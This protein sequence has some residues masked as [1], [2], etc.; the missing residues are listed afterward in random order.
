MS[1]SHK[2]KASG[3]NHKETAKA[4]DLESKEVLEEVVAQLV[5]DETMKP[6]I[7]ID[8]DE[9]PAQDAT[10]AQADTSAEIEDMRNKYLRLLAEYDNFRKRSKAERETTYRDARS[11]AVTRFLPI[12]DNLE[13]ALKTEC[14]DEAFYKGIEMTM[15]HLTEIMQSLDVVEI[16]AV[17][18]PFDPNRHNAVMTIEDP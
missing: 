4:E 17:G 11:D 8:L 9:T 3:A 6:E 18:Q 2:N 15:T 16:E 13:R 1:K 14:T 7:D 12:Y 10:S 5:D